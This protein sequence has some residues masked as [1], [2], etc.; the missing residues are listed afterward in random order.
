M[1]SFSFSN[2]RIRINARGASNSNAEMASGADLLSYF[3]LSFRH[4]APSFL[5]KPTGGL[6]SAPLPKFVKHRSR[7]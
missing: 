7:L 2:L 6:A 1:R 5:L 3:L 4:V